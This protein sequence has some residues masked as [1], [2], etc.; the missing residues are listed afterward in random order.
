MEKVGPAVQVHVRKVP[1]CLAKQYFQGL[2]LGLV[3]R[4][5]WAAKLLPC[6]VLEIRAS[7]WLG[8]II[9]HNKPAVLQANNISFFLDQRRPS[10]GYI[11]MRLRGMATLIIFLFASDFLWIGTYTFLLWSCLRGRITLSFCKIIIPLVILMPFILLSSGTSLHQ[12]FPFLHLRSVT[13]PLFLPFWLQTCCYILCPK[14][15]PSLDPAS[16]LNCCLIS[17]F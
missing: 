7:G 17:S 14:T 2:D 1:Q 3:I 6:V 8:L 4:S 5:H 13:F 12:S 9:I 15:N 11:S 10:T 16:A